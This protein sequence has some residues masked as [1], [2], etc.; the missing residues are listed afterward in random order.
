[1]MALV[2]CLA[3]EFQVTLPVVAKHTFGGQASTYGFLTSAMGIGAVVGGLY[4]AARGK[5]GVRALI[6]SAAIFSVVLAAA[7]LAPTLWLELLAHV[8]RSVRPA[9]ASCPRA[10]AHCSWRPAR[11]CAA[12]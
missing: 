7:S 2:G 3:Y 1:M 12:G 8:R 4:V 5:T 6:N 10:T 11:R 9:S